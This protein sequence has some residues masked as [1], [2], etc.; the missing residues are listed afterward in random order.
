MKES[1]KLS[2]SL[3]NI[4]SENEE[5][6]KKTSKSFFGFFKKD[7]RR[8]KV[9]EGVDSADDLN[10]GF[11]DA[12]SGQVLVGV[13]E[14]TLR[15]AEAPSAEAAEVTEFLAT[16]PTFS[17]KRAEPEESEKE[18]KSS[19]VSEPALLKSMFGPFVSTNGG[20]YRE[21]TK[22]G[23]FTTSTPLKV[24]ARRVGGRIIS[25]PENLFLLN[26]QNIFKLHDFR[27]R[28]S[29]IVPW[30]GYSTDENKT[31]VKFTDFDV[32][33]LNFIFSKYGALASKEE[34]QDPIDLAIIK[35]VK[36][37]EKLKSY[38]QQK[39]T[40]FDPISKMTNAT[41]LDSE[42]KTFY[43]SKG[44]PQVIIELCHLE[45]ALKKEVNDAVNQLAEK[46]NRTLGVAH[47]SDGKVWE[48]LGLLSLSDP[49]RVDSVD[50]IQK[51]KEHGI[52]IKMLTCKAK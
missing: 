20:V 22:P 46:G 28:Q 23:G 31:F 17:P 37:L 26:N 43:V 35:G 10:V 7:G 3:P 44:A 21:E 6:V 45:E 48:F 39:F 51:A 47:S 30:I 25:D 32:E 8:G 1:K 29:A 41:I 19:K 24:P 5:N 42:G 4:G 13:K 9:L 34:N 49:L 33:A 52:N 50:M 16:G 12:T 36:D 2:R 15:A 40:P 18:A 11:G 14:T 38:T 27:N